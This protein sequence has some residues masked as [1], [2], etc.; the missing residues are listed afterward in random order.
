MTLNSSVLLNADADAPAQ[1][2]ADVLLGPLSELRG[3]QDVLPR[4][5]VQ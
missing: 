3:P 5:Q 2:Q 1:S 4:Y